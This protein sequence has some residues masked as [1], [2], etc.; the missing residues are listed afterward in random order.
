[1]DQGIINNFKVHYRKSWLQHMGPT[2]KPRDWDEAKHIQRLANDLVK[3]GQIR[4]VMDIQNF[5]EPPEEVIVESPYDLLNHV[6]ETFSEVRLIDYDDD[7]EER[8]IE[9]IPTANAL[10]AVT[11]FIDFE[12]QQENPDLALLIKLRQRQRALTVE[13]LKKGASGTQRSLDSYF[14]NNST[15][16]SH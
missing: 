8:G 16:N 2:K 14:E 13:Q 1:M 3:A 5:I 10:T 9:P 7:V 15:A 11:H 4:E 12:E 6:A